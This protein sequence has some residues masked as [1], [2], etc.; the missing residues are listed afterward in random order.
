MP[1][2]VFDPTMLDYLGTQVCVFQHPVFAVFVDL[3]GHLIEVH[4]DEGADRDWK[5][6]Q[7]SD[8]FVKDVDF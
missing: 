4:Q 8:L 5:H 7:V 3:S 2:Q 6:L 1:L